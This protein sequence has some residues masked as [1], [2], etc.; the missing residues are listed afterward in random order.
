MLVRTLDLEGGGFGDSLT[1]IRE[2]NESQRVRWPHKGVDW[3]NPHWLG[4]RTKH[5]LHARFKTVRPTTIRRKKRT[6]STNSGLK[7]L[8]Y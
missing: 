3:E 6:I 8:H 5:P 4:R 7:L 1:S 2:R